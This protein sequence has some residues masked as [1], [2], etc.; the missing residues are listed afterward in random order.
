MFP[1]SKILW[2]VFGKR[3]LQNVIFL[4]KELSR[5]FGQTCYKDEKMHFYFSCF[6]SICQ[7]KQTL[8]E[9]KKKREERQR[10]QKSVK[11][12]I[13]R[14]CNWERKIYIPLS[15]LKSFFTVINNLKINFILIGQ[16][17]CFLN[18]ALLGKR[19]PFAIPN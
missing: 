15:H 5:Y 2:Q 13:K 17:N 3:L 4:T 14:F 12:N 9:R 18:T 16:N 6:L 8:W 11:Q 1:K 7:N 19:K 10:K